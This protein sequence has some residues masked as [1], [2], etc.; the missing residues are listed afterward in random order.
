MYNVCNMYTIYIK[1]I[2][3]IIHNTDYAYMT[4]NMYYIYRIHLVYMLYMTY[5]H[6]CIIPEVCINDLL[7]CV[8]W[9]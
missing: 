5:S 1:P 6:I 7:H 8:I 3:C 4:Y 2:M 9:W